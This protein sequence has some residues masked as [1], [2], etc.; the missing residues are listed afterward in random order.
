MKPPTAV[1]VIG[2]A[3][4]ALFSPAVVAQD[5]DHPPQ[6]TPTSA[7]FERRDRIISEEDLRILLRADEILFDESV[8]NRED[9][10]ACDDDESESKW[11][12]FCALQKA[13]GLF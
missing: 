10:R 1:I 4:F 9:D 5:G 12:L 13:C 8:W 7:E 3:I 2:T 6:I 11:S